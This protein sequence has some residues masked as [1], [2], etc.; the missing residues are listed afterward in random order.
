VLIRNQTNFA[1]EF[2][3]FLLSAL[4]CVLAHQDEKIKQSLTLILENFQSVRAREKKHWV[5]SLN[6][7]ECV[8]VRGVP[9]GWEHWLF[10]EAAGQS[11]TACSWLHAE[12]GVHS[13]SDWGGHR[14]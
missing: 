14:D 11:Q 3:H 5:P 4:T 1:C 8:R 12:A 9:E 10:P 2:V 6:E 13:G 7:E